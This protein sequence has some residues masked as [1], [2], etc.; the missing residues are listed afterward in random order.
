MTRCRIDTIK[1]SGSIY[2]ECRFWICFLNRGLGFRFCVI[3]DYIIHYI[4]SIV[5]LD[6][7]RLSWAWLLL[8]NQCLHLSTSPTVDR[9]SSFDSTNSSPPAL[10]S[11]AMHSVVSAS[12]VRV[13]KPVMSIVSA[14]NL[15]AK[16]SVMPRDKEGCR[17]W[18]SKSFRDEFHSTL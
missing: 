8:L 3:G 15:I 17:F 2:V 7:E 13:K 14:I 12:Q 9:H 11:W 1:Y 18:T 5:S 6:W 16:S 4:I 10:A